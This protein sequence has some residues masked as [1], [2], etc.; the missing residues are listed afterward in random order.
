M[1]E[2]THYFWN[3]THGL[4]PFGSPLI[5]DETGKLSGPLTGKRPHN[6]YPINSLVLD[7]L[8]IEIEVHNQTNVCT[9]AIEDPTLIDLFDISKFKKY[10]SIHAQGSDIKLVNIYK[11]D[12][13]Y[14]MFQGSSING[15]TAPVYNTPNITFGN[16]QS[17]QQITLNLVNRNYIKHIN[18]DGTNYTIGEEITDIFE[19][20]KELHL[21]ADTF[22]TTDRSSLI[23]KLCNL[24]VNRRYDHMSTGDL[25]KLVL[26]RGYEM[27]ADRTELLDKLRDLDATAKPKPEGD[28]I[29]HHIP[30]KII[31]YN[32]S[33]LSVDSDY[34]SLY[35][36]VFPKWSDIFRDNYFL[37][38]TMDI[39]YG[40]REMK[41]IE[42]GVKKH[43]ESIQIFKEALEATK[44]II[45]LNKGAIESYKG[46]IESYKG[47]IESKL[48]D[49]KRFSKISERAKKRMQK[50]MQ[51]LGI[52]MEILD[53]EKSIDLYE[54]K[55]KED[56]KQIKESEKKLKDFTE[57]LK[58]N[59]E[60][61]EKKEGYYKSLLKEKTESKKH[62][63]TEKERKSLGQ[64][65]IYTDRT[66]SRRKRRKELKTYKSQKRT[67]SQRS[68]GR[69]YRKYKTKKHKKYKKFK[70]KKVKKVKKI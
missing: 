66:R 41:D 28:F 4:I 14:T 59:E 38:V 15:P 64:P 2:Q 45:E 18:Y 32:S 6:I 62:F 39:D 61:K 26:K 65:K 54:K 60:K 13:E 3:N 20:D 10:L 68:G 12:K 67:K 33:C 49:Q 23:E 31:L 1:E 70:V 34:I 27:G 47:A 40:D 17:L 24:S 22:T 53:Y 29:W 42:E 46:V 21:H 9:H 36:E 44:G 69:K 16:E 19:E 50:R 58:D 8:S 51:K 7:N 43:D 35:F 63:K 57:L 5:L 48:K 56:E 37:G 55:I 11:D 25:N 52:P 30:I